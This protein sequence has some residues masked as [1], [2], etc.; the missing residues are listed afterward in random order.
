MADL[1]TF[2][3]ELARW[4]HLERNETKKEAA[5]RQKKRRLLER[6]F[7][8]R[9]EPWRVPMEATLME[10][11]LF[12]RE[13]GPTSPTQSKLGGRPYFPRN[14]SPLSSGPYPNNQRWS[15]WPKDKNGHELLLLIQL[16]FAEMPSLPC[17][18]REGILQVFVDASDW[19]NLDRG[20]QTFFHAELDDDVVDFE[21]VQTDHFRVSEGALFFE[22]E[23]EF[24]TRDD[25]RFDDA[26]GSFRP[27]SFDDEAR[28]SGFN[29]CRDYLRI[30]HHRFRTH[31]DVGRGRNKVSGYHYSQNENDPRHD[32]PGWED[33][34]LLVQFQDYDE[35]S[36]GDCGS[37]QFFIKRADLLARDFSDLLFHWDST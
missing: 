21:D 11:A 29:L 35:L 2:L 31:E 6:E 26:I 22:L 33:S 36:W 15:A 23:P 4:R 27:R 3:A 16:N 19:H 14:Y 5:N 24:M 17:F 34:L 25:F 9:L 28:L 32:R 1:K 8:S 13:L 12:R 7:P 18:P 10:A 20:L 37:A 30:T